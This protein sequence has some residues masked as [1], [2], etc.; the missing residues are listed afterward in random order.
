[1]GHKPE[2]FTT[3]EGPGGR[4]VCD[5]TKRGRAEYRR[6]VEVMRERQGELCA[7]CG[8][9][10]GPEAATFDHER[11][12]GMGA[13]FRDDRLEVDGRPINAAV[14]FMCNVRRGSRRTEYLIQPR[15]SLGLELEQKLE[16]E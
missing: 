12:R 4:E 16:G 6:R 14:H 7:I 15:V 13:G 5:K 1:M 3:P 8:L 2:P 9:Y 11:P 10:L